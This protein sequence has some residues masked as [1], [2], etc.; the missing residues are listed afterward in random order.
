M[1]SVL[2]AQALV[3]NRNWQPIHTCSVRRALHL[4]WL[5]H[6]RVVQVDGEECYSTH[7]LAS[8]MRHSDGA[9]DA[10]LIHAVR[11]ALR[12]PR[13]LVLGVY[14]KLPRLEVRFTRRNVFVRDNFTCQ[15]CARV[16]PENQLNL[17]HVV[18]RDKG[19]RTTWANIVTSCVKCNSRKA[20]KMPEEARMHPMNPPR[21][22]R[23]RPLFGVVEERNVHESWSM[24]I[25]SNAGDRRLS[26]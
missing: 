22:P 13:V 7:D 11:V 6:A 21:A 18:P 12:V 19:G 3:L 9:P 20:N 2:N 24:F 15:Y 10:E 5:G 25:A 8:W 4:L 14:D 17:D 26:A 1:S 23:W 16:L